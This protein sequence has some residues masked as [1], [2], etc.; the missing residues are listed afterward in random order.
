MRAA[1]F[2]GD[3]RGLAIDKIKAKAIAKGLATEAELAGLSDTQIQQFI[4]RAGF[5]TAEAVTSVSGR[6][7]TLDVAAE[8]GGPHRLGDRPPP[9]ARRAHDDRAG[10]A[11]SRPEQR[12]E[13]DRAGAQDR[14]ARA[15]R[16]PREIDRVQADGQRLDESTVGP[17]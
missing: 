9:L 7:A 11:P 14:D 15:R 8:R 3:G 6:G 13:R 12:G 10:A 5:S 4:F 2:Q 16:H 1:R 17:G